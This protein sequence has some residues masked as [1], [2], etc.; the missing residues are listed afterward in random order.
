[1][2]NFPTSRVALL[3]LILIAS[4]CSQPGNSDVVR[5]ELGVTGY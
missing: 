5:L 1:M 3:P 2:W 4:A